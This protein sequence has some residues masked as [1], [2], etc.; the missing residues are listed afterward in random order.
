MTRATPSVSWSTPAP[1]VYGTVLSSTQLNAT[2]GVAGSFSYSPVAGTVLPAGSGQT[3]TATF[4][5][6]DPTNYTTAAANVTITV[7]SAAGRDVR[8]VHD[9]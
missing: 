9:D 2:A 7:T 1:I 5:P 8:G 6:T 3:L 4:T